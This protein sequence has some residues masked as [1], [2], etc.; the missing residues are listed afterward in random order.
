MHLPHTYDI[1]AMFGEFEKRALQVR[2][3]FDILVYLV[4]LDYSIL[5]YDI[6]QL[7]INTLCKN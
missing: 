5:A 3:L 2:F 4:R 7:I 6:Y 1:L